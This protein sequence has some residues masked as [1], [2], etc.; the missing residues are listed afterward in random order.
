MT[1]RL[2][3][4]IA[5]RDRYERSQNVSAGRIWQRAHL[6]ATAH[7]LAARPA[8]QAAELVD[9]ERLHNKV[10][11]AA[12]ALAALTDDSAWQPTLIF[13]IRYATHEAHATVRRSV[14]DVLI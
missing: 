9:Q 5:V 2:L 12:A 7:G 6:L 8:N 3:G 10:P 4:A 13:Y 1:G 11:R 14:Q